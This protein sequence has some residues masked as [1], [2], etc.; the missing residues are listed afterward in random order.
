[1]NPELEKTIKKYNKIYVIELFFI[2][3]VIIVLATLKLTGVIPSSSRFRHIFNIVTT[4]GFVWIVT[5]FIWMIFSKKRQVKNSWFDKIS[6]LPFAIA[7]IAIDII[8]FIHWND[9]SIAYFTIYISICFYYFA[10][11]YI[12]QGIYHIYRPSPAMKE[13][14]IEEYNQKQ[15]ELK[16]QEEESEEDK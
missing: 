1:M 6:L 11:A 3:A 13:A 2:A 9:E 15:K 7:L 12:A 5:D 16:I 14:A 4:L 10:S 8:G